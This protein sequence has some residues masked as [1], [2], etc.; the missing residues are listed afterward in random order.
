MCFRLFSEY[1]SPL[2]LVPHP[3]QPIEA[4]CLSR[5]L[6]MVSSPPLPAL[7][8]P[9]KTLTPGSCPWRGGR[10]VC[11]CQISARRNSPS[12][13][14]ALFLLHFRLRP[15]GIA[16]ASRDLSYSCFPCPSY[17]S[18]ATH[19]DAHNTHMHTHTCTHMHTH[20]NTH[21]VS[22]VIIHVTYALY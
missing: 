20:D 8:F 15:Y 6:P 11:C 4:G 2:T 13:L 5:E 18:H 1:L 17:G 3:I 16:L 21:Y 9:C 22:Y 7:I 10:D 14:P 12:S 19:T